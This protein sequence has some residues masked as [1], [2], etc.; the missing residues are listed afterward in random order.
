MKKTAALA[1]ALFLLPCACGLADQ[2][3]PNASVAPVAPA[4]PLVVGV[5][6]M[7]QDGNRAALFTLQLSAEAGEAAGDARVE[8][9]AALLEERFSQ[10]RAAAIF[11]QAASRGGQRIAQRESLYQDGRIASM[12]LI[13]QGEQADGLDGCSCAGLTLDLATG[14]ELTFADLF[15]DADAAAAAMEAVIERD[16]LP[17]LSDYL[18]FADLLPVPRDCFWFDET[19]LTVGYDDERYRTFSGRSG[20]VHFAWQELAAQ[21][22][23]DSPIFSLS[24]PQAAD[25]DALAAQVAQGRFGVGLP[26]GLGDR[27]GDAL[28][29]LPLLADPD[30]TTD[31]R[32]Y[33][34]EDSALRGFA[35]EIPLYADTAPEDTPVSA[36]RA[37]RVS[38][39]GLTTGETAREQI[40]SL[41]GEPDRTL[42]YDA[43]DARDHMLAPGESLLYALGGRVLEAHLD[44]DGV[45]SCL[46][47]RDAFPERLY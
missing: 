21:I 46:I 13:W 24:R 43:D 27:M 6:P 25:A 9:V 11:S 40:V 23:E 37:S 29:A 34:F 33:L 42:S 45:L 17:E 10:S 15:S 30:Y 18:E 41:L 4:A 8:A 31:S 26:Y 38:L 32:V 14:R 20:T 28:A 1:L 19:G 7:E 5:A 39:H 2:A 3:A 36:V 16:V 12:G 47:L 44:G 22:G 35:L